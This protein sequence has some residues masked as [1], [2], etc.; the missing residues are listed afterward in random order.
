MV[1]ESGLQGRLQNLIDFD[2]YKRFPYFTLRR[3]DH[4]SMAHG[5]EVRVPFCQLGIADLAR[6][7]ADS[8]KIEGLKSKRAVL[9][10]GMGVVPCEILTRPKQGFMLP[11]EFMLRAGEQL[12]DFAAD[13]VLSA[14]A[15]QRGILQS[16]RVADLVDK[17][18]TEPSIKKAMVLWALMI[19]EI[20]L[21]QQKRHIQIQ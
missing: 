2:L 21:S 18:R 10:A 13:I 11:I 5:V 7:F 20:W 1:R 9:S 16:D 6:S 19:L 8:L 12:F 3:L 14:S 17:Q 15:K 4:L